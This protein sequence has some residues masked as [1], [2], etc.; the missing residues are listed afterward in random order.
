MSL[1]CR[2]VILQKGLDAFPDA[3]VICRL[4]AEDEAEHVVEVNHLNGRLSDRSADE[5]WAPSHEDPPHVSL[6]WVVPRNPHLG[7][8]KQS[9]VG[10]ARPLEVRGCPQDHCST[11]G[12]DKNWRDVG[13]IFPVKMIRYL[14][15]GV[16]LEC[17][18]T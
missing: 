3:I 7:L 10:I 12:Q 4:D 2:A 9:L 8:V 14:F 17:S 6:L 13:V 5:G 15:L 1:Q 16:D 11:V 18:V